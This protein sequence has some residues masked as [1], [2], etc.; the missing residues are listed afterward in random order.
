MRCA[1]AGRLL[2]RRMRDVSRL[3]RLLAQLAARTPAQV[4]DP[5]RREAAVALL[6]VPDP[7]RILLIRRA[8]RDGDPWSGQIALPGGRRDATDADLLDTAVRETLEETGIALPPA[9][10]R[11][12]LDDLAPVTPVLP[13]VVVRP[14]A[15][16]L[17][18]EPPVVANHEVAAAAW[19]TFAQLEDPAIRRPA[20]LLVLGAPRMVTGY[21]LPAGLL[22]GMTERILTPVIAA[23]GSM[24]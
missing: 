5:G 6:M 21:H 7:D 16:L 2:R 14:F 22:W 23:W 18:E 1:A 9:R 15:F 24:D 4:S 8:T 19:V 13:P 11:A 20:E 12:T 3:E 17:D 10:L